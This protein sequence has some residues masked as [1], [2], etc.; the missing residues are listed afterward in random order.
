MTNRMTGAICE[1][2]TGMTDVFDVWDRMVVEAGKQQKKLVF[3]G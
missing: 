1:P 3:G 2:I